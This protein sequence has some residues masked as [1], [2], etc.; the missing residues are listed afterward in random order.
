[1]QTKVFSISATPETLPDLNRS[2]LDEALIE[3]FSCSRVSSTILR[4]LSVKCRPVSYQRLMDEMRFGKTARSERDEV[5]ASAVRAVLSITQA[6]G[7]VRQTRDG[8]SITDAGRDIQRRIES[9]TRVTSA[10]ALHPAPARG[11]LAG[12]S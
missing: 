5:P 6:A 4:L 3:Y 11:A 2:G 1:M 8:F 9:G 10:R 7:L 12:S